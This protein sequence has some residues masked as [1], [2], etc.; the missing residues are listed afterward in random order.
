MLD[1]AFIVILIL[2]GVKGFWGG[3]SHEIRG[4]L[5]MGLTLLLALLPVSEISADL[6]SGGLTPEFSWCMGYSLA[7]LF[8]FPICYFGIY[9]VSRELNYFGKQI[10]LLKR[11][12]GAGFSMLKG[13]VFLTLL[14]TLL[15]RIPLESSALKN[16]HL[17]KAFNLTTTTEEKQP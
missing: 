1:S 7:A 14:S 17:L 16:S 9:L 11:C 12:L 15:F 10:P 4:L 3:D 8:I 13:M 6:Q 5:A 2:F